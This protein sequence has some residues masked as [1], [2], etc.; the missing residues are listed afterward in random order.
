MPL[1]S[2]APGLRGGEWLLQPSD[3][4]GVFTPDQLS[5]E[6]R[7]IGQTVSDFVTNEVL[8]SLDRLEQKDWTLARELVQRA[9]ALGLLGVDAP[10]AYGGV[11]L[12]KITSMIVSERMARSASFGATFGAQANLTVLPL[13]LFGTE[14]QKQKY[15][16]RLLSGELIGAYCLS[17]PGSGSDALGARTRATRQPDGSFVLN[18]EKAWITN[19]G[20]ADV[21]IVFA[22]VDG[23][24]FTAFIVERAFKGVSNGK[25]EHKMGLHGSSTTPVILQD[26]H[27]PAEN[28]LGE[29]GKGHKIAF[30]VLNFARFKLGGMCNGAAHAAIGEAARYAGQ[31]KQFGQPIASFGAIK[32]KIGEMI[33]RTYAVES[34]LYRTAGLIEAR[35]D[36][37]PHEP[38]DQSVALATL[39]E[40]AIEASI[41]KVAGSEVLDFVLDENIQIHGGNGFVR[42]YPAEGHYRDSRVNRIFEGT[43]EINRLL[44]PG[45]LAR[46]AVKGDLGIIAAAKSLQDELLGPPSMT[47]ADGSLLGEEQTAVKS[48][49]KACLLVLGLAMQ[50]YREKIA[51]Q[52]EVLMHLADMIIDAYSADSAVLRALSVSAKK[53]P[54][55]DLQVV[56]ARVFVNDAAM[57]VEASARQALGAMT[58]G[59]MLRTSVSALKRLFKQMPINTAAMRRQLADEAVARGA[60]IFG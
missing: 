54:K 21:Y 27:V 49:K 43:N 44:I 28:L 10:E 20:F 22:K 17:E 42:D 32:H 39:E 45:M 41:A 5:D 33:V 4:A 26:V 3:S 38:A 56:A 57:R 1:T 9:G 48:F 23:E 18:G 34:L 24:L 15:L 31:R 29:I 58:E 7:L 30:N 16:P 36:A 46:R 19:G 25:E 2:A 60:Y 35:I 40:Y 52:Q 13:V 50:T 51:D 47:T 12:D 8:P 59:D 6:H 14:A 53:L 37:T 55:A 11:Q